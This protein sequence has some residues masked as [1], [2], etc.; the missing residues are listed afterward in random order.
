MKCTAVPCEGVF[1][2]AE[3][4]AAWIVAY[5]RP[6]PPTP[7]NLGDMVRLIAGFA[8]FL[9]RTGDGDPGPNTLWEGRQRVQAFAAGIAAAKAAFIR[10]D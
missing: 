6:P 9:G 10:S 7:P 5:R 1:N 4:Q 8:G 3:W 2:P